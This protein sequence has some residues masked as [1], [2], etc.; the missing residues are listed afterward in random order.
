[1]QNLFPENI[2]GLIYQLNTLVVLI[3]LILLILEN[4]DSQTAIIWILIISFFP[5]VGLFFYL[6]FG[7]SWRK[8]SLLKKSAEEE[9]R[10]YQEKHSLNH[11]NYLHKLQRLDPTAASDIKKVTT[12]LY[13][14]SMATLSFANQPELFFSGN[15][16]F[17]R[18]FEDIEKAEKTIHMDFFIWKSD[19]LGNRMADALIKKASQGVQVRLIFDG[20]GSIMR[21][22][23]KYRSRLKKAGIHYHYFLDLRHWKSQWRIN[24]N[25]HKKI[26]VIDGKIAYLGGMNMGQEYIDGGHF[27]YWRD[28]QIRLTGSTVGL[29]ESAFLIDWSNCLG[30][31][32]PE[33]IPPIPGEEEGNVPVQIGLSGP[34]SHWSTLKLAYFTLITNAAEEVLIQSPYF[35]PDQSI[36]EALTSAALS[37][38]RVELMITGI[39]D[40][41]TAWW[42]A[43]TY[44]A[45]LLDAGVQIYLYEKGFLHAKVFIV[46]SHI[47]SVGTCNMDIRSFSYNYEIN[48]LIYNRGTA[49]D[50]RVQFMRDRVHCR[51]IE[52][53]EMQE[54]GL[55]KRFRNSIMRIFSP[56]L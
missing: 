42:A 17:N 11:L 51:K 21:I 56:L 31:E 23:R 30:E 32:V 33:E 27:S 34:D 47:S 44:F 26:V 16:F 50:L 3:T 28:T 6:I 10:K 35:V 43:H 48:A 15:D 13:K 29:V 9:L 24:Y 19:K 8:S 39:P 54:M 4:R 25:N 53:Q 5:G 49:S 52:L 7:R 2:I 41:R 22:S 38:I 1:M 45:P 20:F 14:G 18:L 36:M 37:G 55:L 46:D 12:L 40:K